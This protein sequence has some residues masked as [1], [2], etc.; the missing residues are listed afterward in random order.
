MS[1]QYRDIGILLNADFP[2][3]YFNN[4]HYFKD[5][6]LDCVAPIVDVNTFFGPKVLSI[7]IISRNYGWSDNP[8]GPD[9]T[10]SWPPAGWADAILRI[11]AKYDLW[12]R[13]KVYF[14]G[15]MNY[16]N[17]QDSDYVDQMEQTIS[18][19]QELVASMADFGWSYKGTI[20]GPVDK[21]HF[22]PFIQEFYSQR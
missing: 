7:C 13:Y 3:K 19:L 18:A 17:D 20:D 11:K 4:Q 9:P 1:T 6:F 2:K 22:E 12:T 16:A 8:D 5:E 10:F 21:D 14:F 15:D